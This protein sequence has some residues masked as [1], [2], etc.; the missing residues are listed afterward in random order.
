MTV[1]ARPLYE[2]SRVGHAALVRELGVVD[3]LRFLNQYTSGSGDYTTERSAWLGDGPLE[4][5]FK[6]VQEADRKRNV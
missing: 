1:Q 4:D 5:L 6:E 2:I 3:A